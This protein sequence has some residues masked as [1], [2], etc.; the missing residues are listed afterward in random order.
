MPLGVRLDSGDLSY[1]GV[2]QRV[3]AGVAAVPG[4]CGTERDGQ[5]RHRACMHAQRDRHAR[6]KHSLVP[7]EGLV[8]QD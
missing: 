6:D 2:P 7:S 3:R 1:Q 5:Y 4:A 8:T